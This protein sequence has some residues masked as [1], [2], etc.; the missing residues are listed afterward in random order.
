MEQENGKEKV[1][2]PTCGEEGT[3]QA[4]RAAVAKA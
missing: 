2:P 3:L 4:K 1:V